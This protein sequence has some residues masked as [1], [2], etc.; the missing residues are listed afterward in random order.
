MRTMKKKRKEPMTKAKMI[1]KM[2]VVKSRPTYSPRFI[3]WFFHYSN[4]LPENQLD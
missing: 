1:V 2:N 4:S 3:G